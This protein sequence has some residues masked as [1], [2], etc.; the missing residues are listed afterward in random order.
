MPV[1]NV[2]DILSMTQVKADQWYADLVK[3]GYR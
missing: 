2:N 1:A 3:E